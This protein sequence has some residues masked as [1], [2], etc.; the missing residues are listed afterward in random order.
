MKIL[1][2]FTA[3]CSAV[4]VSGQTS[5]SGSSKPASVSD[6]GQE[7]NVAAVR[8]FNAG[9]FDEALIFAKKAI[10]ILDKSDGKHLLAVASAWRNLAYI[11]LKLNK[12]KEAEA[13][14]DN[15]LS[16]YEISRPLSRADE[17]TLAEM[18]E[19]A[20]YFDIGDGAVS[21]SASRLNRAI[22]LREKINGV[23]AAETAAPIIT[24]G[25]IHHARGQYEKAVPLLIRGLEISSKNGKLSGDASQML[26]ETAMCSLMKIDR[27]DKAEETSRKYR[28]STV[29]PPGI[30]RDGTISGGQITGKALFLAIPAYPAEARQQRAQ[31]AVG[32]KVLIDEAGKVIFACGIS[33]PKILQSAA[34]NSAYQSRFAPTQLSGKP[35]KVSGV[36][37]YNFIH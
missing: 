11:E 30:P 26:R 20:A 6:E 37:T 27:K 9:K 15:A 34:E 29:G 32:V 35:V 31:G 2:L 12:R 22:A 17:A 5:G 16:I 18:L 24:L 8:L 1:I 7:M 10:A 19:A 14:F 21:K 13:A 3:I 4:F 25:Q 23:E 36:I 28:S 33:G